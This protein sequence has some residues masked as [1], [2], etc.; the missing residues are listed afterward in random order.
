MKFLQL[1]KK[2]NLVY[3][4]AIILI[5]GTGFIFTPKQNNIIIVSAEETMQEVIYSNKDDNVQD[6][7][8]IDTIENDIGMSIEESLYKQ[9]NN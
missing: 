2:K 9:L 6:S 3:F 4:L 7:A 1:F 5:F 8:I